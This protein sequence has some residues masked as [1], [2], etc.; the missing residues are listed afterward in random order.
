MFLTEDHSRIPPD[1]ATKIK[2]I[3]WDYAISYDNVDDFRD[4]GKILSMQLVNMLVRAGFDPKLQIN[5]FEEDAVG[6]ESDASANNNVVNIKKQYLNRFP[7]D[8]RPLYINNRPSRVALREFTNVLI[9]ELTHVKQF[10]NGMPIRDIRKSA[11]T[12]DFKFW[13]AHLADE[14]KKPTYDY[15]TISHTELQVIGSQLAHEAMLKLQDWVSEDMDE[16][17]SMMGIGDS[18]NKFNNFINKVLDLTANA[19]GTATYRDALTLRRLDGTPFSHKDPVEHRALVLLYRS[20][21]K[22]LNDWV[23]GHDPDQAKYD[24]AVANRKTRNANREYVE[25]PQVRIN[26]NFK[27]FRR[28]ARHLLVD[29]L[30]SRQLV[31]MVFNNFMSTGHEFFDLSENRMFSVITEYVPFEFTNSDSFVDESGKMHISTQ[32]M[33]PIFEQAK[34]DMNTDDGVN[35]AKFRDNLN[36][37]FVGEMKKIVRDNRQPWGE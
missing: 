31:R 21:V 29:K 2:K 26:Q 15:H 20:F 25:N 12:F 13:F 8:R 11:L 28:L 30:Q 19:A 24:K 4:H 33:R 1:V 3:I 36:H 7:E 34:H 5:M 10:A 37:A 6:G 9:H 18:K 14:T 32:K 23:Y 22:T 17:Y 16:I 35:Y 27:K